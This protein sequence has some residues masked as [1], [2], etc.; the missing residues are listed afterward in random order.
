MVVSYSTPKFVRRM[1]PWGGE[2][3]AEVAESYRSTRQHAGWC[4]ESGS[5]RSLQE[6]LLYLISSSKYT[7]SY[8]NIL[9][10]IGG[11]A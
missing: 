1:L 6:L 8:T 9:D 2:C 10:M 5:Y 4:V 7:T 11:V 3:S